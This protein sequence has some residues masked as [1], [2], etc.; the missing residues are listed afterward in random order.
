MYV[1]VHCLSHVQQCDDS[2]KCVEVEE[3]ID[4]TNGDGYNKMKNTST[5]NYFLKV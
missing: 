5:S 3:G 2:Q 1:Y 4:E